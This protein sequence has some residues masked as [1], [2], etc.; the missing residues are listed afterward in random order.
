MILG[1]IALLTGKTGEIIIMACFGALTLYIVSMMAVLALRKKEPGLSRPFKV[2]FYPF[3]PWIALIIAVISLIAMTS[4]NLR[5]SL[6]YFGIL[7]A[8]YLW[9]YFFVKPTHHAQ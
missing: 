2:P 7:A 5:L 3:F 4:L 6:I 8:A 1:I 9:F